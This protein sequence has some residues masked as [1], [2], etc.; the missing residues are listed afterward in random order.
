[1]ERRD[2]TLFRTRKVGPTVEPENA[3]ELSDVLTCVHVL[4]ES[5]A[6]LPLDLFLRGDGSGKKD[7]DHSLQELVRW[8]PNPEMTSYD[9]RLWMMVDAILRGNGAAQ[10]IRDGNGKVL[11]LWPLFSSKLKAKRSSSGEVM[12]SYKSST[13]GAKDVALKSNEVLLIKS[14]GSGGLFSPSLVNLAADLLSGAKAAEEY[15]REF[16]ANGTTLSGVIEFPDVLDDAAFGRLKKDWEDAH[17]SQGNRHK[18]PI[19]EGGAEFKALALNHQE[20]QMMES[21]KFT[22]SQIAGLLRVPAHMI[23]DLEKATFSN[24]E[25][26]DLGFTKHTLR[27][28]MANWEQRLRMTLLTEAEKKTHYFKHNTNDLLRGDLKSRYEAYA[29]GVQNGILSPNAALKKEDEPTYKGG[30]THFVNGNMIPV[31]TAANR[32][33]EEPE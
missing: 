32:K 13:K 24:I 29:I 9:L 5:M 7:R 14:F 10:V 22:R 25:H 19:L 26:Q 16:F 4:S 8:Q 11:Q 1:M 3:M 17:T 12:Y 15:T 6:A 23:N 2:G 18:T 27:P 31:E 28:W 30:D 33:P 20:T 21:R